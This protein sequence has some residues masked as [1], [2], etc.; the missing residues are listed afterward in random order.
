MIAGALGLSRDRTG[1]G[2]G[3]VGGGGN[4]GYVRP[5]IKIERKLSGKELDDKIIRIRE[6]NRRIEAEHQK[7]EVDA[8]VHSP[9]RSR[10]PS[11]NDDGRGSRE[12]R[13]LKRASAQRR[14]S[15]AETEIE[16]LKRELDRAVQAKIDTEREVA[17]EKKLKAAGSG[18]LN[19]DA[20]KSSDSLD[21]QSLSLEKQPS[22]T[23]FKKTS[24]LN[25]PFDRPSRPRFPSDGAS[26]DS[27]RSVPSSAVELV[28]E[29]KDEGDGGWG[30]GGGGDATPTRSLTPIANST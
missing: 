15:Q 29:E 16:R 26:L 5:E 18:S 10:E 17:R 11:V 20:S 22:P 8:L 1:A 30:E 2:T 12:E 21:L 19:W 13:E 24:P 4:G 3:G 9:T 14:L 25:S 27:R 7:E 23:Y 6:E 28:S